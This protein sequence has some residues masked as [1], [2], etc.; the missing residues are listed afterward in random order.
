MRMP[1]FLAVVTFAVLVVV[2][3]GFIRK[4]KPAPVEVPTVAAAD[5]GSLVDAA[6]AVARADAAPAPVHDAGRSLVVAVAQPPDASLPIR[7]LLGKETERLTAPLEVWQRQVAPKFARFFTAD[8]T[9]TIIGWL[10]DMC[11]EDLIM[12]RSNRHDTEASGDMFDA[13]RENRRGV[14]ERILALGNGRVSK[15]DLMEVLTSD[16]Y[17]EACANMPRPDGDGG[18]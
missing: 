9:A 4:P 8:E 10:M 1:R 16:D 5:A 13:M 6:P 12:I 3:Y 17:A 2:Y 18:P 14:V 7:E 15:D 11:Q